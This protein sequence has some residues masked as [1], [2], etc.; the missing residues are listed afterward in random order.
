MLSNGFSG[1]VMMNIK[2]KHYSLKIW[3]SVAKEAYLAL[4]PELD[5][6][7]AYGRTYEEAAQNVLELAK[8]WIEEHEERGLVLPEP[9]LW[10]D[11]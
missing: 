11:E 6:C 8:R 3:W 7:K 10:P 9:K 2:Y 5:G 4:I 1:R